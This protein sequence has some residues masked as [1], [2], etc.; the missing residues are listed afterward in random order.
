MPGVTAG[1]RPASSPAVL[2]TQRDGPVRFITAH[3]GWFDWR[4]GQLWRYRELIGLL[5]WRDF[6]S[7]YKQTI[8]GPA[9]HVIRPLITTLLFTL[10][11]SRMAGL[12][13]DG[14]PA[15]LF[16]LTGTVA[17]TYFASCLDNT[18]KTFITHA[19]L[20]GKVS[21]HRLVIPTAIVISNLIAFVIQFAILM[22]V[23]AI[24]AVSGTPL[25][26]TAWALLIPV[27]LVILAGFSLGG[28][29]IVCAMTTRYRDL[30]YIVTFGTQ[31]LMYVTPVI[32]PLSAVPARYQW[33]ALANPLTPVFESLR[34]GLLGTGTV[35]PAQLAG[36]AATMIVVLLVGLLLFTRAD[37]T[38]MDTV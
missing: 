36:S 15:F 9:W 10:V 2:E 19:P 3:R 20:L 22:V 28:G 29:I 26:L 33:I 13:T 27:L 11:F 18:A 6:V 5:V 1:P 21:F 35:T 37:R 16:Y 24:Y 17:W 25:Q 31:S 8:L 7:V 12:S 4:L 34:R 14:A 23:M 32:Y 38:F 30:G